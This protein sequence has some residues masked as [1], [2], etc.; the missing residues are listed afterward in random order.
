MT[1]KCTCK[2]D[3]CR[4]PSQKEA[5]NAPNGLIDAMTRGMSDEMIA[6]MTAADPLR[7]VGENPKRDAYDLQIDAATWTKDLASSKI[8]E[9]MIA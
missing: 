8:C 1:C 9:N 7:T 3:K 5:V 6:R 4:D 2:S